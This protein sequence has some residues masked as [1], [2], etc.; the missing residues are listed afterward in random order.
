MLIRTKSQRTNKE[1]FDD[2]NQDL[3]RRFDPLLGRRYFRG[4]LQS[5]WGHCG[6]AGSH[7]SAFVDRGIE[8]SFGTVDY[9]HD[10]RGSLSAQ[11]A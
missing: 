7:D 11:K 4:S 9:D 2:S 3:N 1:N 10:E 6:I 5:E 8:H